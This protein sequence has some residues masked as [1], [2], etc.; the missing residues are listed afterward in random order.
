VVRQ[1]VENG[2]LLAGFTPDAC[3]RSG[4]VLEL[5]TERGEYRSE[6]EVAG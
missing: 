6:L 3:G 2:G 1:E 5:K 4:G